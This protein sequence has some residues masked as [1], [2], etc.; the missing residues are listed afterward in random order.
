M[1]NIKV[2]VDYP[3][4]DGTKLKFR[5]PCESTEVE[6]LVVTYPIKNGVGNAIKTFV[7]VDAHG[8]ELSGVGNVFTSD[9]LIEVLL[10]VTKGRAYVKNA[11]TNS[12]IEDIKITVKR[13]DEERQAIFAEAGKS[14]KECNDATKKADDAAKTLNLSAEE[15]RSGGF[16]EALKDLNHGDKFHF[17]PGTQ[18][19]FDEKKDTIPSGTLCIITDE[20]EG[21]LPHIGEVADETEFDVKLTEIVVEMVD[22]QR[23]SF[24]IKVS[25]LGSETV[26][27]YSWLTTVYKATDNYAIVE[28]ESL[29]NWHT[30]VRKQL[31]NGG[32]LPFEWET[33]PMMPGVEYR[34]TERWNGKPVYAMFVDFGNLPNAKLK[35]ANI[36]PKNA[37]VLELRGLI[38][39]VNDSGNAIS[40]P[41]AVSEKISDFYIDAT[42]GYVGVKTTED[43]SNRYAKIFVKYTKD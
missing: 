38:T 11:D 3:I 7:F 35:S 4:S 19:E 18:A 25:Q 14:V 40:I 29:F 24:L 31:N 6:G 26:P 36:I 13:M 34:T 33:P 28:M 8:K 9:V 10:D 1:A 2:K 21:V 16:V 15:I 27:E 32:W 42:N 43:V 23:K 39:Y 30:K 12:Y 37:N 5:T 41:L 17:W 20:V 22:G